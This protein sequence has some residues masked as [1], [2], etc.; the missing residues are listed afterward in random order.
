MT[1]T[2]APPTSPSTPRTRETDPESEV[3]AFLAGRSAPCP[4]CAYDLRDIPTARCPECGEPLI[5]KVGSPRARF[6]WFLL[7]I[8]P[9]CFSGVAAAFLLVPIVG[10]T[11]QRAMLGGVQGPPWPVVVADMFGFCSA[12]SVWFM[13]HHRHRIL[14]M[15][16]RKQAGFAAAVWGVHFTMFVLVLLALWF[17]V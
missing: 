15:P 9:G 7:A 6:G 8:A 5:L 14:A 3:V 16:V 10:T 12:A 4:R 2:S 11:I 13:Y 17:L 1:S